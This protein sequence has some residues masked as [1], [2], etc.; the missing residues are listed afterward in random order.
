MHPQFQ[1]IRFLDVMRGFAVVIMVMGHSID[2]VL[3]L[4]VRTTEVFR[5][6][7]AVRGFTGP[8]FLF[9]AGYAFAVATEKRWLEFHV[10]GR[11]VVKR[12]AKILLLFVIGYALHFPFFSFDKILHHAT[13]EEYAQ[14]FQVDVL[15]CLAAS[16]LMLQIGVLLIRT[17]RTFAVTVLLAAAGIVIA[18]PLVWQ[19]QFAPLFSQFVAPYF[20]GLALTIFPVFPYAG[21]FFFGTG[22]GHFYLEARGE[23]NERL[24][25]QR[26]IAVACVVMVAGLIFDA[27]PWEIY[28]PHDFWRSSPN[29]FMIR[30][31]IVLL[32]T[33]GFCSLTRIPSMVNT[34]LVTLG[35]A[36]LLVYI[37]HL[38][39]VYGS[40]ANDGLMQRIGQ[41][42]PFQQAF[43]VGLIVLLAMIA[44]VYIWNYVRDHHLVVLRFAQAIATS[45]LLFYFFTKPW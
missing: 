9:V 22:V 39:L 13:P 26:V 29:F 2:S 20:N 19:V 10:P 14:F 41:V 43:A 11:A 24:F 3:S 1:R 32:I 34:I 7:D 44:L 33:A 45:T 38:V 37:A 8:M 31:G 27:L 36:S 25:F 12:L 23:G 6:Y 17:A 15:H 30:L 16:M 40:A 18:T 35:Q 42:L 21:F 4:D 28:P 5:L